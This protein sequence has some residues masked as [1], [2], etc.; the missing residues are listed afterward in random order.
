MFINPIAFQIGPISIHW[1]GVLFAVAAVAAA[2]LATREAR[3]RGE[4]AEQVWSMLLVA[5]IGGLIG[6]RLY[7][8]IH[9]GTSIRR[10]RR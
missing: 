2:W 8:V 10:T 3:R 6:A 7:H 5:A 9:N 4:D 1:Y